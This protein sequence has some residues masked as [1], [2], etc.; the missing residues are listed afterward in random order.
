MIRLCID[1]E[2]NFDLSGRAYSPMSVTPVEFPNFAS[3]LTQEDILFNR[4]GF[5]QA[6]QIKHTFSKTRSSPIYNPNAPIYWTVEEILKQCGKIKTFN[7]LVSS[8]AGVEWQG[9][10]F[11]A[12]GNML[13]RFESS[14]QII[15]YLK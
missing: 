5:P 6:F 14:T 15:Q 8:R 3:F 12:D 4:T 11:D 1:S 7:I 13:G 2:D 9:V 10:V